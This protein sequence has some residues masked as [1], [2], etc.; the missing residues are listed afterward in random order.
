MSSLILS[1]RDLDFLLYEWLDAS[2]LTALPRFAEHS[3]ETFDA[4]LDMS[5]RMATD[6]FAPHYRKSDLNEPQFDGERVSIIPEVGEA[7]AA[8]RDAGLF[9]GSQDYELGGMQL[10][11][12][13]E[14][15]AFAAP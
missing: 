8:Y 1:R 7:L 11:L 3:R 5:E 6:L 13:V 12:L 4:V 10:P 2:A 14:K 9:A 15:A